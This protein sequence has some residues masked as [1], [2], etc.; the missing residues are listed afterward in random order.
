LTKHQDTQEHLKQGQPLQD[1]TLQSSLVAPLPAG[2]AGSHGVLGGWQLAVSAYSRQSKEALEF[3]TF[4]T[5][6]DTQLTVAKQGFLPALPTLY[7]NKELQTY[8]PAFSE[9][10][11]KLPELFRN[12]V[13]RPSTVTGR[14]Y[15]QVSAVIQKVLQESIERE[16]SAQETI[17]LLTD[18][19][20]TIKNGQW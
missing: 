2:E 16:Q 8:H 3:L 11:A 1:Q 6:Y 13:A 4:M 14:H 10:F 20:S 17:A 7:R 15:P 19:L 9:T 5:S 18:E 12:A